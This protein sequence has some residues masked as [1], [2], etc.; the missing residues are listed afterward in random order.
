VTY[1]GLNL[2]VQAALLFCFSHV[3]SPSV[4]SG[5]SSSVKLLYFHD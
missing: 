3:L 1:S 2:G 4:K 5:I